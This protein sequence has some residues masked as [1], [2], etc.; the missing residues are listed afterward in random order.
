M[1]LAKSQFECT[2]STEGS[3]E[4]RSRTLISRINCRGCSE[5]RR[6]GHAAAEKTLQMCTFCQAASPLHNPGF[7]SEWGICRRETRPGEIRRRGD[8]GW[9]HQT[10]SLRSY[11]RS[12]PPRLHCVFFLRPASLWKWDMWN[13]HE[14]CNVKLIL[15][16]TSHLWDSLNLGQSSTESHQPAP[17]LF[18]GAEML[19]D[20]LPVVSLAVFLF[21][22]M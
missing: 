13:S 1:S 21:R 2:E 19:W 6:N 9:H 4:L 15:E 10:G 5:I 20:C 3:A 17:R 16:I 12:K 11:S 18:P 14:G 8:A 22:R 7:W